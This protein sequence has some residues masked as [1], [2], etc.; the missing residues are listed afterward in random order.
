MVA[1]RQLVAIG[2]TPKAIKHRLRTGRLRPVF[3][4]VYAVGRAELSREG[5]WM[6]A[7]LA[8]GDGAFLTH[9]SAGAL[10]G[11]CEERPGRTEVGVP[12]PHGRSPEDI[13]LR[14]R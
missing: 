9:L 5:R 13:R 10:Y 12:R 11:I 8:C 3:R 2:F 14:R 4:G 7:V 1:H 6:A